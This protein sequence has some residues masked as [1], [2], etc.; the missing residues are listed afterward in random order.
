[1]DGRPSVYFDWE[2][3]PDGVVRR[4]MDQQQA[5]NAATI[6]AKSEVLRTK[7]KSPQKAAQPTSLLVGERVQLSGIGK[8]RFPR[9]EIEQG[10]VVGVPKYGGR[11]VQVIFDGNTQPTK[12]HPSYVEPAPDDLPDAQRSRSL[13]R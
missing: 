10:S 1:M 7:Y 2:D 3:Y 13:L 6:F 4:K 9:A 5:R 8:A 11:W 12:V